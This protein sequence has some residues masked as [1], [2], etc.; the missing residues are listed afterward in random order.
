VR[1]PRLARGGLGSGPSRRHSPRSNIVLIL[2]ADPRHAN[3]DCPEVEKN[4]VYMV[5]RLERLQRILSAPPSR[6][7]VKISCPRRTAVIA[8]AYSASP[9]LAR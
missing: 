3:R 8:P 2:A 4:Y 6:W 7:C 9:V 5:T 1:F